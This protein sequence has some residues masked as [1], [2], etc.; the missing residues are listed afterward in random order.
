MTNLIREISRSCYQEGL[1]LVTGAR[2]PGSPHWYR[3]QSLCAQR[4]E[5][6][7]YV[8]ERHRYGTGENII[9]RRAGTRNPTEQVVVSA[10]YDGVPG[11]PGADDNASGVAGVLEVARVLAMQEH[12]RTLVI[13]C[14][15]EE[16]TGLVGSGVYA[17]RA[18][19]RR[20]DIR[21]AYVFEMIGYRNSAVDSQK[22]P[23]GFELAFPEQVKQIRSGGNRGDF[24]AVVVDERAD[25]R[26]AAAHFARVGHDVGLSVVVLALSRTQKNHEM[27]SDLQRSDHSSFWAS[28]Y[29]ALMITDTANFRN[30]NY[31]CGAGPD[32]VGDLDP[33]FSSMVLQATVGSVAELLR[34]SAKRS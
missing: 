9:G 5:A 11:C 17:E 34:G 28:S 33:A 31:H 29:P 20:E 32:V 2:P 12:D 27:F 6:L 19:E 8:V 23:P 14:W 15:D 25:S 16:E 1:E 10:H 7:G 3:V 21:S 18:R 26:C 22:L 30:P 4:L 13:A 24:I